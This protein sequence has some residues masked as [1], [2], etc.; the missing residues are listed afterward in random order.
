MRRLMQTIMALPSISSKPGLEVVHEVLG[1]LGD[2]L[3]G[4][5]DG[6]ELRP[7][8]LEGLLVLDFLALGGLLEVRVDIRLFSTRPGSAWP[9]CSHSRW[10]L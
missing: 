2:P 1:N 4:A 9:A 3:F 7:L 5:Y 8:G 10:G 6:L